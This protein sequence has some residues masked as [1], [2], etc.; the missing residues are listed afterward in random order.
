MR[1]P[2]ALT[3]KHVLENEISYLIGEN[4]TVCIVFENQKIAGYISRIFSLED[5]GINQKYIS[6]NLVHKLVLPGDDTELDLNDMLTFEVN[7]NCDDW[8]IVV[9]V[10]PEE[11]TPAQKTTF[12]QADFLCAQRSSELIAFSKQNVEIWGFEI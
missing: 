3:P 4:S 6:I 11:I 9:F 2:I 1:Q 7:R 5:N 8:K 12:L 10:N